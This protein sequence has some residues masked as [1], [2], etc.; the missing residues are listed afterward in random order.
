MEKI[1]IGLDIDNVITDFDKDLLKEFLAEDKNKRNTGI[2][3]PK[4]T[5]ISKGMF[6]WSK[7]E[8]DEFFANNMQRIAMSLPARRNAGK[9]IN[10]LLSEGFEIYLISH[11]VFPHY[12]EPY[13]VTYNWLRKHNINYTKLILSKEPDKT[14]ECLEY[15]IDMMVDDRV[16][17]CKIMSENG[18]NVF[19]MRTRYNIWENHNLKE[20]T[21]WNKLYQEAQKLK[22]QKSDC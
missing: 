22:L 3:N 8:V 11:R 7:E 21:S 5:H 16:S 6:D 20:I 1:R 10:K 9:V 14:E 12:T 2:I 19:V 18:I 17:Q 13:E 4:S 15:K